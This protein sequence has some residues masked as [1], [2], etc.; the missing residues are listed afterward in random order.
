MAA[1]ELYKRG[2]NKQ[3]DSVTGYSQVAPETRRR[4]LA[5]RRYDTE[6]ELR[7]RRVLH[8]I[9]YRFRLHRKDL[10]GTP[11]IVLP[12]HRKIVLVHGCFWHG[13]ED[14]KRATRPVNNAGIWAAKIEGNRRRDQRNLGALSELGWDVLVVWECEVRDLPRLEA[15]LRAFIEHRKGHSLRF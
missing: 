10:P 2:S 5:V 9:G 12:R 13:H 11:D 3:D 7:V 8:A 15:R 4:M 6:P 1:S 14:C